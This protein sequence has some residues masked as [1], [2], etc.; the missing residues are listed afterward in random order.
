MRREKNEKDKR[1]SQS[2]QDFPKDFDGALIHLR[3][4]MRLLDQRATKEI[5]VE[6]FSIADKGIPFLKNK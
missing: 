1:S 5:Q 2:D 3:V 4:F 6:H